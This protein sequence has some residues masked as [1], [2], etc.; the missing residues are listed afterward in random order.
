M[1]RG[2]RALDPELSELVAEV[3]IP[4]VGATLL[5][6]WWSPLH[7][8]AAWQLRFADQR[9]LKGVRF[10]SPAAADRVEYLLGLLG[11]RYFP[12]I[13]SRRG[14]AMLFQWI[15]GAPFGS[16][17]WRADSLRQCGFLHGWI[18]AHAPVGAAA[19]GST[20]DWGAGLDAAAETLAKLGM[21]ARAEAGELIGQARVYLPPTAATG[22]THGDLCAENL[23][24]QQSDRLYLIDNETL[25]VNALDYDLARTWYRWPMRRDQWT[26]YGE[27]YSEHRG[28]ADFDAHFRYWSV[29]VLL[30]AA[31]WHL[32]KGTGAASI[33]LHRLLAL[34]RLWSKTRASSARA[35]GL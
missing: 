17:R 30:E 8:R 35:A 22:I 32:T 11:D 1:T 34:R 3:G 27:G 7:P 20:R 31:V 4:L 26:A 2:T 6:R 15:E 16:D 29:L 19:P 9:V 18:H 5:T 14:P 24:V 10:D 28:L 21:L 12:R 23:I 25:E 33:P 13:V